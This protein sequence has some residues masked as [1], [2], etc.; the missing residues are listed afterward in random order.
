MKKRNVVPLVLLALLSA[1]D[2]SSAP[3]VSASAA[4]P[5]ATPPDPPFVGRVWRSITPG[6]A[7]GTIVVFLPDRS[8]LMTSCKETYRLSQWAVTGDTIRWIED[9][10]PIQAT[11]SMPRPNELQLRIAGKDQVESYVAARAP[12]TCPDNR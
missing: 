7:P 6:H 11:V 9:T 5:E 4:A 1:C 8:L 3:P 2:G 12:Y 10:I